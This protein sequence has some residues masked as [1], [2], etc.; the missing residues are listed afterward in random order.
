MYESS[1]SYYNTKMTTYQMFVVRGSL[2]EE[3]QK[4][5]KSTHA[6]NVIC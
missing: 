1:F 2:Q 5:V 6:N 4:M 3:E